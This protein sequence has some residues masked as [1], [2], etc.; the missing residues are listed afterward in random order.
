MSLTL[1]TL[2]FPVALILLAM[3][4]AYLSAQYHLDLWGY[5]FWVVVTAC[6]FQIYWLYLVSDRT[7]R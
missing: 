7:R 1:G 6:L 2:N 4:L 5:V 3:L